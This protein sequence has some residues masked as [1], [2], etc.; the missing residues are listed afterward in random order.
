MCIRDRASWLTHV[1]SNSGGQLQARFV[2]CWNPTH[3]NTPHHAE[4][5]EREGG[6][7]SGKQQQRT[8]KHHTPEVG[9][10]QAWRAGHR[11]GPA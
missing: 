9:R 11:A 4:A 10:R 3:A 6:A 2:I 8:A 1:A 5:G 7:A